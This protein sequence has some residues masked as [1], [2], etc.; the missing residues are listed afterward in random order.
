MSIPIIDPQKAKQIQQDMRLDETISKIDTILS[1]IAN[2][3]GVG[4]S[5]V[6]V[7]LAA[8]LADMGKKV[9]ILDADVT[10][11]NIPKMLN[12]EG[13]RL[14]VIDGKL[15]PHQVGNIKVVSMSFLLS[16]SDTPVIWRGPLKMGVLKQFLSDV[17]WGKMDYLIVDLPP[18]TSD[19]ALSIAQLMPNLDGF[20][21]VTTPQ[22]VSL[23]DVS[24]SIKFAA[25]VKLPVLGLIENMSGLTCPKCGH[26]I[27]V[28]GKGSALKFAKSYD[29]TFLG[30]IPLNPEICKSGDDGKPFVKSK[31]AE[32]AAFISIAEKL[33]VEVTKVKEGKKAA[34]SSNAETAK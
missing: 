22:A 14:D 6:A 9:G 12:I 11:P 25:A 33:L 17:N 20:V 5:T 32:A 23:L 34:D 1:V 27:D 24:K 15:I 13:K 18:G 26:E 16:D 10:G 8:T 21:A 2:K 29:L 7:N 19:E 3:G 4:K 28:F 31:C 30:S